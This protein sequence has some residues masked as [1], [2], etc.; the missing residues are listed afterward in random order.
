MVPQKGVACMDTDERAERAREN[1]RSGYNCPQSVVHAFDDVLEANGVDPDVALRLASPFGGGMGRL[2]EVCGAVTGM[3]MLLG[4]ME[5][6]SDPEEYDGKAALY[7][8]A[9]RLAEEFRRQQ[10]SILCRDLLGLS[11]GPSESAPER[12]TQAYYES[13]PCAELCACA[14]KLVAEKACQKKGSFGTL[15]GLAPAK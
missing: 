14:A 10:G 2:R 12:R 6:F 3:F 5:G 13:R 8:D 1:F 15:R 9:Q 7:E 4:L 11:E